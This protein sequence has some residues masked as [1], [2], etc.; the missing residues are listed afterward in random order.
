MKYFDRSISFL[1]ARMRERRR[2]RRCCAVGNRRQ[3]A[4][5]RVVTAFCVEIELADLVVADLLKEDLFKARDRLIFLRRIGVTVVARHSSPPSSMYFR[6]SSA[7]CTA[8]FF[9]S[10]RR[11]IS[12]S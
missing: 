1:R 7:H 11:P 9:V 3:T 5:R 12:N 6:C 8:S 10:N 2:L 4:K